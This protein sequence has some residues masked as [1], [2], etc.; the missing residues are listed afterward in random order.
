MGLTWANADSS[1]TSPKTMKKKPPAFA[2]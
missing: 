1:A 2:V